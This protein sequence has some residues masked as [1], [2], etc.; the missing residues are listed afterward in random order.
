MGI[1]ETAKTGEFLFPKHGF[2]T[3]AWD[4]PR[5]GSDFERVG[6]LEVFTLAFANLQDCDPPQLNFGGITGATATYRNA[7]ELLLMNF[8]TFERGY[9][10]CQKCGY[11][12]SESQSGHAG[13][14]NL[15]SWFE[16]HAPLNSADADLR[17]WTRREAPVWRNHHLAAK[18]STHLLV[19]LR[20]ACVVDGFYRLIPVLK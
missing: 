6:K 5:H 14:V 8:G 15:P 17:C 16:W 18:Q 3:A 20:Q 2:S 19:L 10:I 13:R 12:E 11:A 9:A 4:P 7:G 1:G